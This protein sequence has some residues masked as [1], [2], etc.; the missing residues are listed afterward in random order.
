MKDF[1]ID[2]TKQRVFVLTENA[3]R[4][5]YIPLKDLHRVDYT[6]LMKLDEADGE[7]LKVMSTTTLENGMNALTQYESL[8]QVA[9]ISGDT[10]H[11]IKK[12]S[13][14]V[15][16]SSKPLTQDPNATMLAI[17]D[18]LTAI[19]SA[20]VAPVTTVAPVTKPRAAKP[21]ATTSK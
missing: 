9:D 10:A 17:L 5:V 15:G 11:R 20:P 12:P 21:R 6:R 18:K 7:L 16:N 3:D 1:T 13:E 8:L 4:V 19:V 2:G 14:K